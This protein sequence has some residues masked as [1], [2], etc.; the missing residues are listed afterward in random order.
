VPNISCFSAWPSSRITLFQSTWRQG[1]VDIS[2]CLGQDCP[3]GKI[4]VS[5]SCTVANGW[6]NHLPAVVISLIWRCGWTLSWSVWLILTSVTL[7]AFHLQG[8]MAYILLNAF[9]CFR[10]SMS[11]LFQAEGGTW[12]SGKQAE[13]TRGERLGKPQLENCFMRRRAISSHLFWAWDLLV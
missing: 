9:Y 10:A 8:K 6:A 3:S 13:K 7:A 1:E 4:S 5:S 2:R 12:V 11:G